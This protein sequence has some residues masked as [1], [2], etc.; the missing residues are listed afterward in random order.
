[1]IEEMDNE[2]EEQYAD[3]DLNEELDAESE[4]TELESAGDLDHTDLLK[5]YLREASRAPMLNAAGDP[6]APAVHQTR[7][8][9]YQDGADAGDARRPLAARLPQRVER[10][11]RPRAAIR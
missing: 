10:A 8:D 1:M 3:A 2:F 6:F 4:A 7:P 9:V 11:A 5:V